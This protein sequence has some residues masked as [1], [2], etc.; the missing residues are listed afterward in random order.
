MLPFEAQPATICVTDAADADPNAQDGDLRGR[1][2]Q[3]NKDTFL[4]ILRQHPD[5]P[6]TLA[7]VLLKKKLGEGG[8]GR[9]Y[10]GLHTRLGIPVA[11]KIMKD[12][13]ATNL[14]KFMTEARLTAQLDH[15]NLVRIYDVNSARVGG[16]A[17]VFYMIMEYIAGISARQALSNSLAAEG[18]PLSPMQSV[19]IILSAALGLGA[20]HEKDIVHLDVK[21]DN[22]LIGDSD[23]IIK[24]ADL[25]LASS[26]KEQKPLD[27]N[28]RIYGSIGYISPEVVMGLQPSPATDV[29]GLGVALYELI[30]GNL[31]FGKP[32]KDYLERQIREGPEDPRAF[33][34]DLPDSLVECVYAALMFDPEERPRDGGAYAQLLQGVLNDLPSPTPA[35]ARIASGHALRAVRQPLVLCVDDDEESLMLM[36]ETLRM[37]GFRS[38]GFARSWEVLPQLSKLRPDVAVINSKMPA[39]NG[40]ELFCEMR[41]TKGFEELP[42]LMISEDGDEPA[43][44]EALA[45]GINDILPKPLDLDQLPV[46][47]GLLAKLAELKSAQASLESRYAQLQ[48]AHAANAGPARAGQAR[49]GDS[50]PELPARRTI[51]VVDDDEDLRELAAAFLE[52]DGY[53]VI[54]ADD[55]HAA[56]GQIA[57]HRPA[58]VLMDIDMPVMDGLTACRRIRSGMIARNTP[59]LM[60]TSHTDRKMVDEAFTCGATDYLSKPIQPSVLQCRLH[61]AL[62]QSDAAG[63]R[64]RYADRINALES[65]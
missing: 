3:E 30:T 20:A 32:D 21:P 38:A 14:G 31:P 18:R 53:R 24:V 5:G 47:V 29:Y 9:V 43:M 49:A 17:G 37:N 50:S 63:K 39:V 56:L 42:T 4:D 59:I 36:Q 48:D 1:A 35:S 19:E 27:M 57:R 45:L 65:V 2:V 10:L 62:I 15:P 46:R 8:M 52:D 33:V 55:G 22:V 7:G 64:R 13:S 6:A 25:G 58:A 23:G 54:E 26:L 16:H 11:V 60:L 34:P 28:S 44:C 12:E 41:T 40:I 61:T 51:L